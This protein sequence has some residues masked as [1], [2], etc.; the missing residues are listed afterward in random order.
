MGAAGGLDAG[1]Q[2]AQ[3][4]GLGFQLDA[5]CSTLRASRSRWS[6]AS[7]RL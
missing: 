7:L 1:F 5:A 3:A 2:V 4:G 6:R